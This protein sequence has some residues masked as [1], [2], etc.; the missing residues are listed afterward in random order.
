M[1]YDPQ[2]SRTRP[3]VAESEPA[4]VEALLEG[5]AAP[6][7]AVSDEASPVQELKQ[8]D[9]ASP[10]AHLREVEVVAGERSQGT[11]AA[12]SSVQRAAIVTALA[13]LGLGALLLFVRRRRRQRG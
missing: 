7:P 11:G 2:R 13:V 9:E 4:P 12:G 5:V 6:Q 8:P 10:V 3:Q 1:P